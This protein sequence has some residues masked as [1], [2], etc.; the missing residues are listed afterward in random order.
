MKMKFNYKKYLFVLIVSMAIACQSGVAT[1]ISG[2]ATTYEGSNDNFPNPER[3]FFT[4]FN[5][6]SNSVSP[7]NIADLQKV[8]SDGNTLIRRLYLLADFREQP[9]SQSFLQMISDDCETA[10][11][12]GIKMI[13]RFSYNWLGGG[14][15]APK[16]RIVS[17][18]E[19]LKPVLQNN[20]DVIAYMEAGFIGYWGEWNKSSN[21]LDT[22]SEARKE[23]LFKELLVL[24]PERMIALRYA[25]YKRDAFNNENPLTAE[26]AFSGSGRARVGAHNDCFLAS[27]DDGGTYNSTQPDLVEKEKTFLSLDNRYVVQGGEICGNNIEYASCANS[28]ND[29][30]R[31]HWSTFN[32]DLTDG[33]Q[34]IDN[35]RK[36]GCLEDI[37]QRLGYRLRLSN[38]IIPETVKAGGTLSMKLEII[39]DG[40]ASLYNSRKVEIILRKQATRE[41]YVLTTNQDPRWWIPNNINVALIE[42][43]LP[44]DIIAGTYDLLLS[45]PD[46]TPK[47]YDKPEYSVRLAN[48]NLW[49]ASTGYNSLLKSIVVNK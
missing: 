24:P 28:L 33:A 7:L 42:G 31:M 40:W 2:I 4:A 9:L 15:D 10:R 22:N 34:V 1:E 38:S 25:P 8:R 3:G 14:D 36:Q 12:A 44:A 47:L 21:G 27:I 23:I 20:F 26:E 48:K 32:F 39:N 11:K 49:E 30:S 19:Q 16:D 17:H 43:S 46:P 18:L 29:L 41:E 13:L 37:K 35:W 45:L 5:P 6:T